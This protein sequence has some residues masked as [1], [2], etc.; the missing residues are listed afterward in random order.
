MEFVI[1]ADKITIPIFIKLFTTRIVANRRSGILYS[2]RA[3]KA[4]FDFFVS[5][6]LIF[7][8]ESEKYAT[9]EPDIRAEDI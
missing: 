9:S 5:K 4:F 6:L 1:K 8:G 2:F 7:E 3:Q